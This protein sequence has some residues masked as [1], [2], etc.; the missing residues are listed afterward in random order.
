MDAV[1]ETPPPYAA[2]LPIKG[3]RVSPQSPHHST[4]S[5]LPSVP[6]QEGVHAA[7]AICDLAVHEVCIDPQLCCCCCS[8]FLSPGPAPC[9]PLLP[10]SRP[11]FPPLDHTGA[12]PGRRRSCCPWP[13][14]FRLS[15]PSIQ[16][17]PARATRPGASPTP[18]PSISVVATLSRAAG[19]AAPPV[20]GRR[21]W[22][23]P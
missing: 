11:S 6:R 12:T 3:P 21:R 10:H 16:A 4:P 5:P 9:C 23:P 1:R 13:R 8:L 20:L 2:S 14:R 19:A 18:P 7:R 15:P 17:V 22:R